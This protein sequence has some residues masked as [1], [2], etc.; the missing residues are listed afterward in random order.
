MKPIL[1]VVILGWIAIATAD[2]EIKEDDILQPEN[3]DVR[4]FM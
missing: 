4:N 2:S 3:Y 1:F